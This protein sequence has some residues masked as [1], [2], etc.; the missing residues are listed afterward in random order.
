MFNWIFEIFSWIKIERN[1]SPKELGRE[2]EKEAIR[3]LKNQ[4]LKILAKN[5]RLGRFE[6]DLIARD[7]EELVFIEV[8]TCRND[9]WSYPEDRVDYKKKKNLKKA[10]IQYIRRYSP[11][12][13]YYRFDIIAITWEPEVSIHWIK[14]AF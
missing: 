14:N 7:S 1:L 8:K 13:K 10:G 3:F 12:T 5:V 2:G 4:G 11:D 9:D 6:I